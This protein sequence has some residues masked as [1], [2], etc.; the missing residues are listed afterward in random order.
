MLLFAYL[1]MWIAP[2][3]WVLDFGRI[4]PFYLSDG[5][6]EDT[7]I[8][9]LVKPLSPYFFPRTGVENAFA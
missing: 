8:S 5:G 1:S 9:I 3:P 7:V 6:N 4:K 2:T